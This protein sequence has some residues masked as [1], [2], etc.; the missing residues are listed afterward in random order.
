ML[1]VLR[2]VGIA[3]GSLVAAWLV[4]SLVGGFLLPFAGVPYRPTDPGATGSGSAIVGLV[5]LILG[6]LIYRDIIRRE[7]PAS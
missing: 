1:R 6:G 3:I 7:R 5:T 4:M 2:R